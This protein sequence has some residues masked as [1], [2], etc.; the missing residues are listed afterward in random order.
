MPRFYIH[1]RTTEQLSMDDV[2]RELPDLEAAKAVALVSAREILA[3]EIKHDTAATLLEVIIADEH[4]KR[5]T[6]AAKE[7]LP[8]PLK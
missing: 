2:G 7:I 3:E 6:I 8:E 1:F 5:L 4:G